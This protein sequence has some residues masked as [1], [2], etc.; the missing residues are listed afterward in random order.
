LSKD[1]ISRRKELIL[2]DERRRR[3][4]ALSSNHYPYYRDRENSATEISSLYSDHRRPSL[5]YW[6]SGLPDLS[7]EFR[8]EQWESKQKEEIHGVDEGDIAD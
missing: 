1:R 5:P 3:E 7:N 6:Q 8:N 4:L 2:E